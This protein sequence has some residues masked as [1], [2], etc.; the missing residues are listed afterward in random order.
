M[1]KEALKAY[2]G[3]KFANC[4]VEE[5]VDFAVLVVNPAD[6]TAV[7]TE[8]KNGSETLFDFL[9]CQ[10]AVDRKTHFEI[11]Y[12]LSSTTYRHDLEVKVKL[13][14]RE[15]PQLESVYPLWKAAELYE[16]EIYDLMGIKF[17]NHPELRRI[18]LG[19]DWKGFPLRKDY[20]DANSIVGL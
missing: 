5:T 18:F 11:I 12:H 1:N 3:S 16:N 4:V 14:N 7:A 2:L 13:D 10:T 8:L 15:T 6:L 9:F 19:D 20:V 17:N